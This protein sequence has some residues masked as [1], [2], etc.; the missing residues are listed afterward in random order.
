M[1]SDHDPVVEVIVQIR[2]R[3]ALEALRQLASEAG[4]PLQ[5]TTPGPDDDLGPTYFVAIRLPLETYQVFI[6]Q[7][8][9][10][11]DVLTAYTKPSGQPA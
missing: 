11:P 6:D 9:Q 2:S 4:G 8:R 1:P 7:A 10:S 3:S 5:R